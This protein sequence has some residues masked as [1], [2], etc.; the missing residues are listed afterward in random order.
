VLKELL[1]LTVHKV[2]LV[3][4]VL[5]EIKEALV[6][7]DQLELPDLQAHRVQ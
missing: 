6:F 5:K 1:E 7:K 3:L 2:L 4:K